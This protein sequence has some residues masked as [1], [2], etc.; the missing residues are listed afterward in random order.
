MQGAM[1]DDRFYGDGGRGTGN[2][3]RLTLYLTDFVG[4]NDWLV[5]GAGSDSH[6]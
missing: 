6:R 4:G 1:G 5:G 3:F 2:P